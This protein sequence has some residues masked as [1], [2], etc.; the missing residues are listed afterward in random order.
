L[1]FML[2]NILCNLG[3]CTIERRNSC[4][5]NIEYGS[6]NRIHCTNQAIFSQEYHGTQFA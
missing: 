3:Y 1:T 4:V 6:L 5:I 2:F